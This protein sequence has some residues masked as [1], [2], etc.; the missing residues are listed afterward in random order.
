MKIGVSKSVSS[1][2]QESA[3]ITTYS[4]R[5]I[6]LLKPEP[7]ILL[8]DD[9]AASLARQDRFVG[10]THREYKV[11]EHCMLGLDYCIPAARFE[12]LMHDATENL[13]GDCA[14]PLKRLA[15]MKFYRD[16]EAVWDEVIRERFGV[17]RK[18]SK[19]V[20]TVDKRML[21]TEQRDLQ[22]RRPISTDKF[23]PFPMS[24]PA[25]APS[26]EHLQ[27]RFIDMFYKLAAQTEG[28]IR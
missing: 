11:A 12:F 17:G 4:G 28:A 8:I 10:H 27:E 20:D 15:G 9:I 21:V 19:E 22:G 5:H 1:E 26:S 13:L 14:G 7:S 25:I 23:R 18:H 6:D 24:I 3:V 16:L 2:L